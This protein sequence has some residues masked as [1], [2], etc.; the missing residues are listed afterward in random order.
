MILWD[1]RNGSVEKLY[2]NN[3]EIAHG[4]VFGLCFTPMISLWSVPLAM[5]T[6]LL[7]SLSGANGHDKYWRRWVMPSV[8]CCA[9]VLTK[10]TFVPLISILL[11]ASVLSLGYGLV[12][13]DPNYPDTIT[14]EGS[15][16]GKLAD[17]IFP[18]VEKKQE[19]FVR[20]VIYL[21]LAISSI[22]CFF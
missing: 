18:G 9:V 7:W 16:L 14:D 20:G 5:I 19:Y 11:Y 4:L 10:G 13:Y 1:N 22:P 17:S 12:T 6:A 21:L 8:V 2:L 15:W 3:N